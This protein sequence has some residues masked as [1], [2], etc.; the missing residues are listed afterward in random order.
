MDR[1][2]VISVSQ[3]VVVDVVSTDRYPVNLDYV[4]HLDQVWVQC[5]RQNEPGTQKTLQV[6]RDAKEKKKHHTV[7]P[8]PIDSHFDLVE[9]LF[10]PPDLKSSSQY[11]YG[12]VSHKNAR[13]L[14]KMDLVGLRYIKS[15]DLTPY[16]C[17]PQ[18]LQFSALCKIS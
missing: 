11:R 12:Y 1:V 4:P 15:V 10:L 13:G 8:E 17:F 16:N 7:H 5:W 9:N 3:M 14:Y 2:L 6:I 18:H